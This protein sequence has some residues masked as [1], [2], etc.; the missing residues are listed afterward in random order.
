M[1]FESRV[2]EDNQ[3]SSSSIYGG[4]S[5]TNYFPPWQAR[6]GNDVSVVVGREGR[7]WRPLSS[8]E[9]AWI[10][11]GLYIYIIILPRNTNFPL[12]I[13]LMLE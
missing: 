12:E 2:I 1:G 7:Y 9:V 3:F 5:T 6:L 11:V 4:N 10:Q 8:S 13:K